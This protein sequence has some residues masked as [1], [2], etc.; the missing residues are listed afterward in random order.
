MQSGVPVFLDAKFLDR[1]RRAYRVASAIDVVVP[2][3]I[4]SSIDARR[5]DVHAALLDDTNIRL[6]EI[7]ANPASTDLFYG[8]DSLCR[9]LTPVPPECFVEE[10]LKSGR[11]RDAERQAQRLASLLKRTASSSI[12]E[13]GPGMGRVAFFA[14]RAGI[15]DYTTIDLP[16]GMVAQ[17]CFLG[18]VLGPDKLWFDGEDDGSSVGKIKLYSADKLPTR[19]YGVAINVDSMTEMPWRKAS[20]YAAWLGEHAQLF[21]SINHARNAFTV[22]ELMAFAGM[23]CRERSGAMDVDGYVPNLGYREEIYALRRRRFAGA[24]S[25]AFHVF[26]SLR[27]RAR[28]ALRALLPLKS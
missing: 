6:R 14:Y 3:S 9:S 28:Q 13:I 25:E 5:A 7:F 11:G 10:A 22:A 21:F 8:C 16:L 19:H 12:V 1:V 2:G 26:I 15:T 27:S 17:A 24:R 18:R 4:W 20:S 23:V